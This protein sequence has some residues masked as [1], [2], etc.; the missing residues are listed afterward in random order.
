[1]LNYGYGILAHQLKARVIAAGLDPT[2][3]I[4][5]GNSQNPIPLIYDLMEPMRP[6]IDRKVLQ[7]ALSNTFTP[8]DFTISK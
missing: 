3:G 7:F 4:I 1:M 5:H 2:I 8:G 6:L